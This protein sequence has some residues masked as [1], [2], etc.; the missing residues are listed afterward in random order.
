M[1]R[2]RKENHDMV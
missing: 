1:A 2:L